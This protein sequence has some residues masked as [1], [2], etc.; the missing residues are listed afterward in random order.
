[1]YG[2]LYCLTAC[3]FTDDEDDEQGRL[4]LALEVIFAGAV[5]RDLQRRGPLTERHE[6]S[7]LY[8]SLTSLYEL[9]MSR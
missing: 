1:V 6:F 7:T 2:T 8:Q 3:S 4:L 9:S 5:P